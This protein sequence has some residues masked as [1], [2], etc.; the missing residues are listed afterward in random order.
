MSDRSCTKA[1]KVLPHANLGI[2]YLVIACLATQLKRNFNDL[3]DT[4]R[5]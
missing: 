3:I 2:G 5:T 1:T 4:S